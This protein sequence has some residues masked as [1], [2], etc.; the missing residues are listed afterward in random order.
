[1]PARYDLSDY[2]CGEEQL[3]DWK[4]KVTESGNALRSH[5]EG[6]G[7]NT[8][9]LEDRYVALVAKRNRHFPPGRI[10]AN[11]STAIGVPSHGD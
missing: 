10:A 1:M 7:R 9:P 5:A 6:Q 8:M 11:L 4:Q 2:D 3:D